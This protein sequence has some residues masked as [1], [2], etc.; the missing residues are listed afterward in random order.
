MSC[1]ILLPVRDA[2]ATLAETLESIGAQT[3]TDFRCLILDDGSRDKS[4]D[5]AA[6]VAARDPRFIVHKMARRGLVAALNEGLAMARAPFVARADADDVL[7]RERI[8]LQVLFLEEN[9]AI[10]AVSSLVHFFGDEVSTDLRSY[11]AWLNATVSHEEIVRDLFVESPLPHP[12]VTMRTAA[13]REA[14]GY[15]QGEFPEDYDLWLRGWRA[16][17]RFAKIPRVLVHI[18]DHPRRLTRTDPRYTP[19]AFLACKAEHFIAARDLVG[20]DVVLWGAGRDG[21]RT[22]R[23]LQRRGVRIRFF[24]DVAPGKIGRSLVKTTVR[25]PDAL[26]EKPGCPVVVAVGVKGA[27]AKIREHLL[28]KGYCEPAE[29]VCFG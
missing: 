28:A 20:R 2:E 3:F 7:D 16:G 24:V 11:E 12:S 6:A 5:L 1:D 25:T 18:R 8:A 10:T 21:V 9:S 14:A 4:A 13:V 26:R 27:R 15:R 23:E 29:F 22:A 19:R 17:W